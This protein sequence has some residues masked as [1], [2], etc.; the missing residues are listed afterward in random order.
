ML[1]KHIECLFANIT[2]NAFTCIIGTVYRPPNS[3]I[4]QFIDTMSDI[5][6][7]ISHLPCYLLGDYNIDL[8]KH[9]SHIQT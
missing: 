4:S 3:N 7:K 5:L 2:N 1:T 6:G 9:D 8:L